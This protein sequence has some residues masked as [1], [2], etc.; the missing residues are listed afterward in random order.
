MDPQVIKINIDLWI[1]NDETI[2]KDEG[3]SRLTTRLKE[4]SYHDDLNGSGHGWKVVSD[5]ATNSKCPGPR[6]IPGGGR[7]FVGKALRLLQVF[8]AEETGDDAAR[9]I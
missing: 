4:P 3:W 5:R 2:T 9:G 1:V 7:T 8:P 6:P